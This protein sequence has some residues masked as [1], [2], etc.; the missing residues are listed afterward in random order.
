M[1]GIPSLRPRGFTL[2]ELLVV[3][4]IIAILIGLLLPAVQKVREAALNASQF[5]SLRPVA[6]DVLTVVGFE[7]GDLEAPLN[8]VLQRAQFIVDTVRGGQ[9]PDTSMIIGVLRDLDAIDAFLDADLKALKNPASSHV[10]GELEAYL[11]LKHELREVATRVH[12]L[13]IQFKKVVDK[14]SP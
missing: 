7:E 11:N 3:I 1:K 2:I 12:L 5:D 8:N 6:S 4:A 14:A 9:T 13:D 10:P